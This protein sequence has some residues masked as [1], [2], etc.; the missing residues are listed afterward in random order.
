[1]R[2]LII[3]VGFLICVAGLYMLFN[4]QGGGIATAA[5]LIGAV[6]TILGLVWPR[7]SR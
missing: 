6:G 7:K 1:M 5:S 4:G 3:I 2:P